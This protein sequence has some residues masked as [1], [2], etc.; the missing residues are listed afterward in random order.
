MNIKPTVFIICKQRRYEHSKICIG[1]D[2][3]NA[4][5]CWQLRDDACSDVETCANTPRF[6]YPYGAMN[7]AVL[8][9]R[10]LIANSCTKGR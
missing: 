2:A 8:G 7:Q 5:R 10:V 9:I 3:I 1:N 4:P 6:S